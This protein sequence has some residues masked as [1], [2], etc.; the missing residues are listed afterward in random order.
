M[1][2]R[3]QRLLA[4]AAA[5][6]WVVSLTLMFVPAFATGHARTFVIM[7][8]VNVGAMAACLTA[9]AVMPVL[10]KDFYR[11]DVA[12]YVASFLA[13]VAAGQGDGEP[14]EPATLHL[15]EGGNRR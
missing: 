9:V 10:L 7:A 8:A 14:D 13:G 2:C 6:L 5:I 11:T 15:L 4:V 12:D 1:L 3:T